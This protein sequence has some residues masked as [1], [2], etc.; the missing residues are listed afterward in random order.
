[1]LPPTQPHSTKILPL[2]HRG[3]FQPQLGNQRLELIEPI[4]IEIQSVESNFT[5]MGLSNS[6]EVKGTFGPWSPTSLE[7]RY[8][9]LI[10]SRIIPP[11]LILL[12][13]EQA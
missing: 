5:A 11:E 10:L 13:L 8:T 9:T 12:I 7:V 4:E 6:K 3:R 2:S 1:M